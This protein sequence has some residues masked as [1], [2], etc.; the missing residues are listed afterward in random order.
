MQDFGMVLATL[1]LALAT[2]L[3]PSIPTFVRYLLYG[4]DYERNTKAMRRH[5]AGRWVGEGTPLLLPGQDG[6]NTYSRTNYTIEMELSFGRRRVKGEGRL[7]FEVDGKSYEQRFSIA[8]GF[9][10]DHFL[11]LEYHSESPLALHFGSVTLEV[12]HVAA[13]TLAGTLS[14]YGAFSKRPVAG[15]LSLKK[16]SL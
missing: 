2:L 11:R 4:L 15:F 13:G 16:Q 14:G 9:L 1:S 3:A 6:E 7:S 12:D 10:A 8:G 5:L